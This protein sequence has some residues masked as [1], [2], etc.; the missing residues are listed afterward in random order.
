MADVGSLCME[1]FS[2]FD[3]EGDAG[4]GL[5]SRADDRR[6][7][8][9]LMQCCIC[10]S[11]VRWIDWQSRK[12]RWQIYLRVLSRSSL[13]LQKHV[14]LPCIDRVVSLSRP[15]AMTELCCQ[16]TLHSPVLDVPMHT[17]G[18]HRSTREAP[19]V[20]LRP[21]VFAVVQLGIYIYIY[22]P[23]YTLHNVS[24]R[25]GPTCLL[26]NHST[27]TDHHDYPDSKPTRPSHR[28]S[29]LV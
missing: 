4:D 16:Y 28:H 10:D 17:T 27:P 29:T 24:P 9:L 11:F 23:S 21:C 5:E 1:S 6:R 22:L 3:G 7:S 8:M 20:I 18:Q 26:S 19:Y 13:E 25:L 2:A 14:L 12:G 15:P